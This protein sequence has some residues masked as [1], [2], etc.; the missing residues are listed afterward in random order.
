[1]AKVIAKRNYLFAHELLD[2]IPFSAK[3]DG[4][5]MCI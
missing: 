1:M 4:L 5:A 3:F 2:S